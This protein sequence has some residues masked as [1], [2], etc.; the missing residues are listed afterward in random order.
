MSVLM[1]LA[2]ANANQNDYEKAI[3]TITS[4]SVVVLKC[5][6]KDCNV[7]NYNPNILKAWQANMDIQDVMNPYAC[8]IYVP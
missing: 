3:S 1:M 4:G 6:P 2:M 7:N 5:N 8:V